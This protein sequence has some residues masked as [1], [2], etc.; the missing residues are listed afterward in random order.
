MKQL[1]MPLLPHR[2][3]LKLRHPAGGERTVEVYAASEDAAAHKACQRLAE[4]TGTYS[5]LWEVVWCIPRRP[6]RRIVRERSTAVRSAP[7]PP[8]LQAAAGWRCARPTHG[9]RR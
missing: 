9:P 8:T 7:T 4:W 5:L 2:Y 3:L 1:R 6:E